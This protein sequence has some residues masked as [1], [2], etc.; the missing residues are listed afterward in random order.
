MPLDRPTLEEDPEVLP[1]ERLPELRTVPLELLPLLLE[2]LTVRPVDR[3]FPKV[4]YMLLER[5]D[6]DGV[7]SQPER[8]FFEAERACMAFEDALFPVPLVN[9]EL[10]ELLSP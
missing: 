8:A 1:V 4:L 3:E 10:L 6:E 9:A 5:V 2:D 7:L